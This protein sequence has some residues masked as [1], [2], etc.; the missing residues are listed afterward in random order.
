MKWIK[1][2][3]LAVVGLVVVAL[4][5]VFLALNSIIRGVVQEQATASLN[6]P[7]T[8]NSVALSLFGGSLSL[9]D[10]EIGSPSSF[11]APH[12][13][14]LGGCGV[15]VHFGQ[16]TGTPIHVSH[17]TLDGLVLYVEQSNLKLN[18][19]ALMDQMPQTP[20][21]S[22]GQPSQPIKLIIDQLDVSN[23]Q[24]NFLPGLPGMNTTIQV[25]IPTLTLT[26][27]GNADGNGNGAAIKDVV[28]Q[29]LT[30]LAAKAGDTAQLPPELKKFLSDD[31]G[32]IAKQLGGEFNKQFQG[33]AGGLG[34]VVNG[35]GKTAGNTVNGVGNAINGLFGGGKKNGQ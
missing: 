20:K 26:N 7:T 34:N 33:V 29:V 4:I 28:M 27:I 6:V 1:R 30:A 15:T 9:S 17:I 12:T 35:A 11:S 22:N 8:L 3:S 19:Q 24:V 23:A 5:V 32:G 25:P 21:S 31:L 18:L 14:T 10:L 16:L 2:I 13:M